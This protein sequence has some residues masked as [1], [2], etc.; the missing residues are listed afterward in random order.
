[1]L[2]NMKKI[3]PLVLILGMAA[4]PAMAA[5]NSTF[6]DR[7]IDTNE[8]TVLAASVFIYLLGSALIF[9]LLPQRKEKKIVPAIIAIGVALAIMA[10]LFYF[11]AFMTGWDITFWTKWIDWTGHAQSV[12]IAVA[13][14][15]LI[16]LLTAYAAYNE[17][18][19][20][21]ERETS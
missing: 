17:K 20:K 15:F 7:D 21:K 16:M 3:A 10:I 5:T 1:M 19:E 2:K 4:L 12:L 9:W 6:G 8:G 11:T 14:A 13:G 18:N